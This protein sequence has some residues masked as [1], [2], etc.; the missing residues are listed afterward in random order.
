MA[1]VSNTT[2]TYD[3]SMIGSVGSE[4]AQSVNGEM[5]NKIR[6]AEEKA[7]IDPITEDIDNIDLEKEKIEE[8]KAKVLEFQNVVNFFDIYNDENVFNQYLYDTSGS[9]A[10]FDATNKSTL[11]EGTTS[12]NVTQLAQKDVYQSNQLTGISDTDNI[13]QGQTIGNNLSIKVGTNDA[14]EFTMYNLNEAGDAIESAKTYQELINEI[15]QK[16]DLQASL[17]EIGTDGGNPI[18]R[19]IIKSAEPGSDNELTITQ[20]GVDFGYA[21]VQSDGT[22]S[23][24]GTTL[25]EGSLEL[26]DN[27]G[28]S[29]LIDT[30]GESY[31]D[32]LNAID[33]DPNFSAVKSDGDTKIKITASDGSTVSVIETGENNLNFAN[34]SK[35]LTAQNLNATIDGVEY[36]VSSNSITTQGSLKI[37]AIELGASTVTVSKDSSAVTVAVETMATKYNELQ[38]MLNEEIYSEEST[39]EDKDTLRTILSDI[40]N[41]LF[42]NYGAES[43]EFGDEEDEYGDQVKAHSNV[44]NNNLTVFM[45]GF[46]L[47]KTGNLNV[48]TDTLQNI[49]NGEDEHYDLDDLKN[50]FTGTYEN[51]GLGVQ[52]KEYLDDL[53]GYNGLLSNYETGIITRKEDLEEDKKEE[54]DRLD[55]KYGIMAEQFS[56][57]SAI[58]AQMEASF[59]SL[60]M[61]I[62]QSTSSN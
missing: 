44:T 19:L 32:I 60:K 40:K 52:M 1:E 26:T 38:K 6:A 14:Y 22:I 54:L 61:M 27:S 42:Q 41:M 49:L 20:N 33:A 3:Y 12:I 17:E 58:I 51:K 15:N 24:W 28:N 29:L 37:T 53:D 35:T 11:K 5:I 4:A 59:S 16:D 23:N 2:S 18:Y 13:A 48:N 55:T 7:K 46:E 57:Y 25:G 39:I 43:P 36:D 30:D 56:A 47:D 62:E 9:A 50:V 45:F 34:S 21:D 31:T 8:I 10:V